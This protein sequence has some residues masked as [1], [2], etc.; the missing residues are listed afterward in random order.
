MKHTGT[1][2][3]SY[4]LL[5]KIFGIEQQ[6]IACILPY[7]TWGVGNTGNNLHASILRVLAVIWISCLLP[8]LA[9]VRD[10]LRGIHTMGAGNHFYECVPCLLPYLENWQSWECPAC[11][12]TWITGNHGDALHAPYLENWHSWGCP[13][14]FLTWRTGDHGDALHAPYLENWH[15]W[16][17]PACLLTWRTGNHGDALHASLPGELAFMGMPCMLPYLENWQSWGCPACSLPGELAFMGMSCMLPYLENWQSWGC[18]ACF[19]T[20]RTGIHG[21]VLHASLPGELAI[22]GMPCMLPYP[23]FRPSCN[24]MKSSIIHKFIFHIITF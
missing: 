14:C 20:W 1:K 19:L 15:S 16:G 4:L 6:K 3:T 10:A 13:A 17:C 11:F 18:P 22:M 8:Y 2:K 9:I 7:S 24:T 12:C 23:S 21:N 5:W